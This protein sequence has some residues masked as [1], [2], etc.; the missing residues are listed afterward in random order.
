MSFGED[1]VHS[2]GNGTTTVTRGRAWPGTTIWTSPFNLHTVRA[3]GAYMGDAAAG[4]LLASD[5]NLE[6]VDLDRYNIDASAG[7]LLPVSVARRHH[8]VPIGRK[9]GAPVVAIADP[10]DVVALDTLRATMG[11]EFV[12]VVAPDDQ[13]EAC[14]DRVYKTDL[15]STPTA[16]ASVGSSTAAS[17]SA[18]NGMIAPAVPPPL[19]DDLSD[20]DPGSEIEAPAGELDQQDPATEWEPPFDTVFDAEPASPRP[21]T[22]EVTVPAGEMEAEETG[23]TFGGDDPAPDSSAPTESHSVPSRTVHAEAGPASSGRR[24]ASSPRR[25]SCGAWPR[26][27]AWNS[28]TSISRASTLRRLP[29]ARSH[30]PAPQRPRHR[31]P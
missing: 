23:Q 16:S 24:V 19:E 30:G 21:N 4:R 31:H 10:N 13:I 8:V 15:E 25:T 26:R 14:L 3:D 18:M 6:Y 28:S 22:D 1:Q 2:G 29:P 7:R 9:F 27:W 11:R 20:L 12:A 17:G 5:H